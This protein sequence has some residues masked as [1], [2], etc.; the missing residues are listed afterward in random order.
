MPLHD[1]HR[2]QFQALQRSF[3]AG[4]AVLVECTDKLDAYTAVIAVAVMRPDGTITMEPIAK[5]FNGK[6]RDEVKP[7]KVG[8]DEDPEDPD[9]A[10][11]DPT[12]AEDPRCEVR[13]KPAKAEGELP[14]LPKSISDFIAKYVAG[15]ITDVDELATGF[16]GIIDAG[17]MEQMPNNIKHTC[18]DFISGGICTPRRL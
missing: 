6:A 3:A 13:D 2:E 7:V 9:A 12:Q 5:L 16:Q 1:D 14:E 4:S 11:S 8:I 17:L 15:D 18:K 10:A